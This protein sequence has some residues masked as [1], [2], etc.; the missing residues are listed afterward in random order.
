MGQSTF[1]APSF[2]STAS[3]TFTGTVTLPSS[4]AL[5][6]AVLTSPFET[7]S[8]S[9][10]ALSGSTAATLAAG[11]SGFFL[12]T[13]NATANWAVNMTGC[14]TTT[15]QSV[16]FVMLVLNGSTA[17]IPSSLSVNGTAAAASGL[18]ASGSSYN[19][20]T[21]WWQGGTAPTTGDA[22]TGDAYTFTVICTGSS[23]WTVI[24]SQV[25]Y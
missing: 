14:P 3:P 2:A 17:Y 21:T 20:I 5:T 1:P 10:T 24:A 12:Y 13:A 25:K 19:N 6:T 22:S 23:T 7:V 18:P 8:V 15:G 9:G 4:T 11:T 16:T